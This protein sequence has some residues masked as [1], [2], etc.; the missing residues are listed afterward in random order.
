MVD[1]LRSLLE[2]YDLIH[3][4]IVFVKDESINLTFMATTLCSI[5]HYF[6]LK[7]QRVYEGVCFGHIMFKACQYATNDER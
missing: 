3:C 2:K 5:I 1:Q 4:M 6:P 7:S